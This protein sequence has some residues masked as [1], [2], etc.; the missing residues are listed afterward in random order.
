MEYK[1]EFKLQEEK[2]EEEY[3]QNHW[4]IALDS[5]EEVNENDLLVVGEESPYQK[6]LNKIKVE[7]TQITE[8]ESEVNSRKLFVSKDPNAR[9]PSIPEAE[10]H[11]RRT[12]TESVV[13]SGDNNKRMTERFIKTVVL[14]DNLKISLIANE[15]TDEVWMQVERNGK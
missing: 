11:H 15:D 2:P 10:L 9:F 12:Y 13:T 14:I 8:I 6:L 3:R 1:M 7:G 4:K 5:G